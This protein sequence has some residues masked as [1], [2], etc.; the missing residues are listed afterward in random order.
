ME[1]FAGLFAST[2]SDIAAEQAL[3]S[4]GTAMS[5]SRAIASAY[6]GVIQVRQCGPSMCCRT[7]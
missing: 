3:A 7:S 6:E 5:L 4:L 2:H 1:G